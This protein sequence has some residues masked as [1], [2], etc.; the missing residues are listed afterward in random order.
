MWGGVGL[1]IRSLLYV[2][3][4]DVE[5]LTENFDVKFRTKQELAFELV[6]LF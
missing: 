1:P 4:K 6:L 5:A 3:Q 2:R